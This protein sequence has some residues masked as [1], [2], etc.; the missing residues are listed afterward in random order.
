MLSVVVLWALRAPRPTGAQWR[1][2][3]IVVDE[4]VGGIS[5][6]DGELLAATVVCALGYA[7][8]G[9]LSRTLGG[10]Q[11]I[12]WALVLAAPLTFAVA[13][14]TLP[15]GGVGADAWLGF[16]YVCVFSMFLGF[17]AWYAGLA[18]G[19][20][21]KAGQVQ[22]LQAPLTLG[23]SAAVLGEHV[24]AGTAV[25]AVG[26]LGSVA[27]TQRARVGRAAVSGRG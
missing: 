26:V 23:L 10:P 12:C 4:G 7:E 6:A 13:A 8:G 27:V 11:T 15:G 2:L 16:A 19:G 24:S 18:L 1:A 9:V 20:V 14:A 22:L 17:F 25:C 21:A 3:A 5:A